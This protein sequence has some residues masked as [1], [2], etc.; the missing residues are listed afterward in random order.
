MDSNNI[1]RN[2]IRAMSPEKKLN[3]SMQLYFSARKL[4]AAWLRQQHQNWTEELIQMK[5]RESFV[6]ARS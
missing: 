4:K 1:Q 6:N 3:I 5:V 2:I